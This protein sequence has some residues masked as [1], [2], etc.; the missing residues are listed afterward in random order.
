MVA[1]GT[2]PDRTEGG[3]MK[4]IRTHNYQID[5]YGYV[6]FIKKNSRY[7][8]RT[9]Y[10]QGF[11]EARKSKKRNPDYLAARASNAFGKASSLFFAKRLVPW[12]TSTMSTTTTTGGWSG[13]KGSTHEIHR[14]PRVE[15]PTQPSARPR[16]R[17]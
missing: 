16:G 2:H 11:L 8:Q 17:R 13:R 6:N 3:K 12:K 5:G 7:R 15:Q 9:F 10:L 1:P 14:L 4:A